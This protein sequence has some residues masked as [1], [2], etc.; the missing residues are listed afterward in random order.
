M[1]KGTSVP[2]VGT[3]KALG[4]TDGTRQGII[5]VQNTYGWNAIGANLPAEYTD[6]RGGEFSSSRNIGVVTDGTKSGLIATISNYQ[7]I[8]WCIKY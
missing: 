5:P 8:M 1:I 4:V 3:G 6:N 2:V 7:D